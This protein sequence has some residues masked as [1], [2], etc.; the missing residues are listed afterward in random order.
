MEKR[1]VLAVLLMTA[2]IL[3]TNILFP[4]P[5]LP[6]EEEPVVVE[7]PVRPELPALQ[8]PPADVAPAQADTVVVSS[9]LYRYA[10]STEGASFARAELTEYPSHVRPGEPVQLIPEDVRH[11]LGQRIVVGA[12]TLDFRAAGFQVVGE[13]AELQ[14]GDEPHTLRF[15]YGDPEALG[16]EISYTFHPANYVV[17]VRGRVFGLAGSTGLVL[18]ELGNGLQPHEDPAHRSERQLAVVARPPEAGVQTLLLERAR[19]HQR[20]EGPFAWAGIKDKY[21]LASLLVPP[22]SPPISAVF[23]EKLADGHY[24]FPRGDRWDT[25][26]VP[27]AHTVVAHP[28]TAE[29]TF[30][31]DAYLGPQEYGRLAAIGQGLQEVNPYGYRWLRPVIRPIAAA[32]LWVLDLFHV[33][34][35]IGYGWVLVVFGVLMRIVLWPLNAK[36]MRAQLKNMAVQPLMQEMRDKHKDDPQRMQQEM[37]KLYKEHGFNPLAGCLPLLVPMPVLITLFFVFQDSI[38]F[39]GASFFWLPDLSLR[40]PLYILPIFL[41]ISMFALQW[42]SAKTSG[43]EQNPQMKMMMYVMPLFIG[44]IFFMLPS[45]LNLYYATTNVATIPQQVLIGRERKRHQEKL[46]QEQA[47]AERAAAPPKTGRGRSKRKAKRKA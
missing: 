39:R 42:I 13:G 46:K 32:I 19:G 6:E 22:M 3:I 26:P 2:V 33:T 35:G 10:L 11:F 47:E 23:T 27:R 37:I 18:T 36:A 4:P 24:T 30:A 8:L 29:G 16:L 1:V 7:A 14:P 45:G 38:A 44:F 12:D 5:P 31:F 17:N 41:V 28:L 40:D 9:P 43:M 25:L 20:M 34:F 21:F 15:A